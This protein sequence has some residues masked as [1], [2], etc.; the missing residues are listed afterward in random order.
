MER[1]VKGRYWEEFEVGEEFHSAART[2][3]EADIVN[4]AGFTGDWHPMHTDDEYARSAHYGARVAHGMIGPVISVGLG[5]R[6]GLMDETVIAFLA[7]EWEFKAPIFIGDTIRQRRI[8]DF[9]RESRKA[10]RGIIRF[11]LEI[12]NQRDEIIQ[13][14]TR[15]LLLKRVPV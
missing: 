6:E 9:K 4:F 15:T 2:I 11:R 12:L 7:M 14:G 1:K 10:D 3:T 8:V 13:Q 5:V